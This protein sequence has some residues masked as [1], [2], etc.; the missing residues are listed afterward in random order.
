MEKNN[1]LVSIVIPVHNGEKYLKESIGSCIN[2]S[3]S[4]IEILVINDAS[5]DGTLE[6]LKEYGD[7]IKIITVEKQN[8]LGNVINIGIREAKG[9]YIARMDIDDIM[10]PTRIHEQVEYLESH[11]DCV[12]LG[13]QIDIID[14]NSKITGHREYALED[15]DIKKNMFLFMPFAHPAVML[16]KSA[17]E[18]VCLYPENMPKVEDVKFFFLLSTKGKFANLSTTVLKYRMTFSTESQSNMVDHFKKTNG[19]RNWAIRELGIRPTVVQYIKWKV[20]TVGVYLFS[21]LPPR[22]FMRVFEFVR[23]VFK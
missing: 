11:P 1:P 22:L 19:I 23:R 7:K 14:E 12:A 18:E 8:G 17:V 2:Q 15:K 6:M 13:G 3:Y 20:E 9:E 4:P 10:Y 16:R 21:I 5:T